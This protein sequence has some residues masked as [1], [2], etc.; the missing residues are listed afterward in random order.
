MGFAK[1]LSNSIVRKLQAQIDLIVIDP[2]FGGNQTGPSGCDGVVFAK[3]INLQIS[4]KLAEGIKNSLN[5]NALLTRESDAAL[6]L[7]ARATFA[8][9]NEADLLI[10]IHTNGS[11]NSSVSGIETFLLNLAPDPDAIRITVVD[12][13]LNPKDIADMHSI[14]SD[15]MQNSSVYESELLAKEVHR[16]L[17]GSL[18][19]KHKNVNNRGVKQAPFYILLGA[20]MPSIVVE[21]GFITNPNECKL[22]SSDEYQDDI[23]IGILEG[24]KNFIEV[25]RTQP[26]NSADPKGRAAD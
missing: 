25:K 5:I 1:D 24:I 2:G 14:L 6:S 11:D 12:N 4:K 10:S 15:L 19:R 21:V 8:N 7:E 17:Y 20:E 22:L 18:E 3:D 16:N 26:V 9:V 13:A 23:S